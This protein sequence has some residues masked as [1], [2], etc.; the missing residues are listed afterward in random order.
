MAFLTRGLGR[1]MGCPCHPGRPLTEDMAES[2]LEETTFFMGLHLKEHFP[3]VAFD[4]KTRFLAGPGGI[5]TR[6]E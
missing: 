6:A 5:V 4:K 1:A 2:P 3:K